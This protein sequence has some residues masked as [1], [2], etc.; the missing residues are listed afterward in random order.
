MDYKDFSA[1]KDTHQRKYH[2]FL[3][4]CLICFA[5]FATIFF[6]S[7]KHTDPDKDLHKHDIPLP[8]QATPPLVDVNA[9]QASQTIPDTEQKVVIRT[10]DT[11]GKIFHRLNLSYSTLHNILKLGK[12][13]Q[14]LLNLQPK[15]EILFIQN[16]AKELIKLSYSISNTENLIVSKEKNRFVV[17]EEK[18]Q[19]EPHTRYA[20]TT[21]KHSLFLA[22]HQAKIPDKLLEE[23]VSSLSWDIDFAKDIR[24]GDRLTVIYEDL[25]LGDRKIQTGRMLAAAFSNRGKTYKIV[26]YT[27]PQGHSEYY[28][29]EGYSV[30][31]AFLRAP[32]K[33]TRISSLFQSGRKHPILHRIRKHQGVDYAAPRGTPIH[34]TADGV[35]SFR[36]RKGGYGNAVILAHGSKY[37]TLYG[38]LSRFEVHAKNGTHVRQGQ[39][40]GYVGSSGLATG[41]HVHYEF[42]IHGKHYNPLTVSLPLAQPIGQRYRKAFAATANNLLAQL[43]LYQSAQRAIS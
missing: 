43:D 1:H 38:H 42:R 2:Y 27:D 39:V 8:E 28:T 31:K 5:I 7:P 23:L 34:A 35:V 41:P 16:S 3:S 19:L 15:H 40:I 20:T 14:P 18:L 4:I 13:I 22:G 11:L 37:S 33:Y 21:I 32:V 26:R 17:R 36:G 6:I 10:G 24:S 25:Y 29:P 9:S 12:S 30:R